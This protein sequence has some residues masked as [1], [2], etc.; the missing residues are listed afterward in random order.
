M[1]PT[2]VVLPTGSDDTR[3]FVDF[4]SKAKALKWKIV[5]ELKNKMGEL[6]LELSRYILTECIFSG[7]AIS[8]LYHSEK[9]KDYDFWIGNPRAIDFAK[10]NIIDNFKDYIAEY[11][12]ANY[13][14]LANTSVEPEPKKVITNNAI[15][16]KNGVQI[17]VIDSYKQCR[18]SFDFIHCMPYY[19]PQLDK[20]VISE[21]Q[22]NSIIKKELVRNETGKEPTQY[23]ID[24]FIGRGWSAIDL[25]L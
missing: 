17:I 25:K 18:K 21:N 16:L 14:Q 23:R 3:S 22:M 20:F 5:D 11:S 8:S 1:I 2:P 19:D 15:T 13:S 24:K 4:P 7:S 12:T 9:P 6:P 10:N